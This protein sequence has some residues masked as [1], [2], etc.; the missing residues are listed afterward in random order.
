[1]WIHDIDLFNGSLPDVT[2]LDTILSSVPVAKSVNELIRC[3]S[4]WVSSE[5]FDGRSC[6][7]CTFTLDDPRFSSVL[8]GNNNEYK[9]TCDTEEG[10]WKWIVEVE[11]HI[12]QYDWTKK[13]IISKVKYTIGYSWR[14]IN[15]RASNDDSYLDNITFEFPDIDEDM[16]I[17]L[18]ARIKQDEG[19]L[20]E[21]VI[22]AFYWM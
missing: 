6:L 12:P 3:P 2:K 5:M 7:S 4:C 10:I 18:L 21:V 1:M 19:K 15:N 16:D 22:R 13:G 11:V 14:V 8:T 17:R 20:K 9:L